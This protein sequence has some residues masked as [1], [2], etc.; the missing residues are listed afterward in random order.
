VLGLA[1][2]DQLLGFGELAADLRKVAAV[3]GEVV[4][5]VAGVAL[6]VTALGRQS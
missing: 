2:L 1:V 6:V 4:A 3:G 5:A